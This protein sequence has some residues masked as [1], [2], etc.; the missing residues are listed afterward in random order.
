[1]TGAGPLNAEE[2]CRGLITRRIP[3]RVLVMDFVT[4]TNDVAWEH[5]GRGSGDGLAVFAEHQAAGR[6]RLGRVWHSPRGAGVL[7]SVVLDDAAGVLK[8]GVVGLICGV[9]ACD[10]VRAATH[11]PVEL[12]WPNDLMVRDRKLGGILVESPPGAGGGRVLVV[13]IGINCLQ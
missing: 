11:V 7:C 13:G 2:I 5:V 6:G 9:A 4:S 1:M 8:G 10:A 12:S 3:S